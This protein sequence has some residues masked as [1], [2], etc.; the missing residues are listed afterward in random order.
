M[1]VGYGIKATIAPGYGQLT[2]DGVYWLAH[3]YSFAYHNMGIDD[4][5]IIRHACFNTLCC[6]PEHLEEGSHYDNYHD[7]IQLHRLATDKLRGT[8]IINGIQYPTVTV[9]SNLTGIS[10]GAIIRNTVDGVFDLDR[11]RNN[12][13]QANRKPKI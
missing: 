10:Q 6:N 12:C 4:F 3:R 5:S 7:S 13:L 9:A 1:G 11:Y 8:W 2:E